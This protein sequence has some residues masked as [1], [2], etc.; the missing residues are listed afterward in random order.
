M[1]SRVREE[2]LP[3]TCGVSI[4]YNFNNHWDTDNIPSIIP[5]GV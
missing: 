1:S 4:F 3:G 2:T 5:G